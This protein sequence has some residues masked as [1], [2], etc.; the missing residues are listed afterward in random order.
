M[1][2]RNVEAI[3]GLAES[4]ADE[5][6]EVAFTFTVHVRRGADLSINPVEVVAEQIEMNL[7][8]SDTSV[9]AGSWVHGSELRTGVIHLTYAGGSVQ[10]ESMGRVPEEHMGFQATI[11]LEARRG[12]AAAYRLAVTRLRRTQRL[13]AVTP[14]SDWPVTVNGWEA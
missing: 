10:Y 4:F 13:L 11:R 5:V 7:A 12:L 1:R 6:V 8:I 2:V 3:S 9:Q 14:E